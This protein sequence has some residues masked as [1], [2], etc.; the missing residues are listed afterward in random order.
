M[1]EGSCGCVRAVHVNCRVCGKDVR[2]SAGEVGFGFC[3]E[4]GVWVYLFWG[5]K[6]KKQC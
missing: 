5:G 3:R 1:L 4:M 2:C 6:E